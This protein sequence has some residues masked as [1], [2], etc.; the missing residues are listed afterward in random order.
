MKRY[1]KIILLVALTTLLL[2]LPACS[3]SV[4]KAPVASPTP[5]GEA[6]FPFTTPDALSAIKTQTAV[7][8]TP[9][10]AAT[11]TP[12]VVMAT[13]EATEASETGVESGSTTGTGGSTEN[14]AADTE[15]GGGVNAPASSEEE[16]YSIPDIT[17][18]ATY[19]LQKGEWPICIARRFDL[20]IS[21]FFAANG[22]NM[23]SK[24]GVGVTLNIPSSGTWS[25]NYGTR[26]LK[27]HPANYTVLAGETVYG[28]ACKFGDVSPEQILAANGLSNASD[29]QSGM[30]IRIP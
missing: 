20:D 18:P 2:L 5:T 22:L 30:N 14:G 3:R 6:P 12:Q 15:A 11:N 4:S 28:I 17:R 16:S 27:A 7:A 21:A 24:P 29:V 9:A 8:L 13:V 23:N 1:A 10:V 25:S 19:T 26:T